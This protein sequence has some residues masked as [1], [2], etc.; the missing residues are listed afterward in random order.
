MKTKATILGLLAAGLALAPVTAAQAQQSTYAVTCSQWVQGYDSNIGA[1][2]QIEACDWVNPQTGA[3]MAQAKLQV[4]STGGGTVEGTLAAFAEDY[5]GGR[6][7]DL[8]N[9]IVTLSAGQVASCYS[10]WVSPPFVWSFAVGA[11][12]TD[13]YGGTLFASYTE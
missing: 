4:V 13:H 10:D 1:Q 6:V 9:C 3:R 8:H 11:L 5:S 7:L 2:L 12:F